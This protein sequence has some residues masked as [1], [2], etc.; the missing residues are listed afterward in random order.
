MFLKIC[1][2]KWQDLFQNY[3]HQ[4]TELFID[5]KDVAVLQVIR[6]PFQN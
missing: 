6:L 1:L 3:F 2:P 5:C 4:F